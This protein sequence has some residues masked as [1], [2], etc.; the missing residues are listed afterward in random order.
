MKKMFASNLE[1][2]HF[3]NLKRCAKYRPS[4]SGLTEIYSLAD[5]ATLGLAISL[6]TSASLALGDRFFGFLLAMR[7]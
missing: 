2:D 5:R 6:M 1:V 7:P 4:Q 3:G